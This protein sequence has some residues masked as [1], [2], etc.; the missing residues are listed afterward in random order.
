MNPKPASMFAFSRPTCNTDASSR[1]SREV[2]EVPGED[3]A[4]LT[5]YV[6]TSETWRDEKAKARGFVIMTLQF[7][8]LASQISESEARLFSE[9]RKAG[10]THPMMGSDL[11][12]FFESE[13]D[14]FYRR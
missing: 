7:R 13:C 3:I 11:M 14:E 1:T 10:L 5:G 2:R 12:R 6:A 8:F 9:L 4:Y